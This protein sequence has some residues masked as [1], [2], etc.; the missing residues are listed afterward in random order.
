MS[1]LRELNQTTKQSKR[2]PYSRELRRCPLSRLFHISSCPSTRT[3]DRSFPL[4]CPSAVP[5]FLIPFLFMGATTQYLVIA[6]MIVGFAIAAP[7]PSILP[8]PCSLG[9]LCLPASWDI[10]VLFYL[11]NYIAHAATVTSSPGDT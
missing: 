4:S 11:F 6:I 9:G 2:Q 7:V 3:L 5:F 8:Q 10:I 1:A